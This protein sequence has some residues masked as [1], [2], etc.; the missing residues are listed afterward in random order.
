MLSFESAQKIVTKELE[1]IQIPDTPADLYDPVRYILKAGGKRIRPSLVLLGCDLFGRD[2]MKAIGPALGIELFHN[3][4]LLH[5]DLMDNSD[6]RRKNPTVHIRWN[7]NVAILSGDVMSIMANQ[8][9]CNVEKHILAHTLI[10][11]CY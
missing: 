11:S 7:P 6:L 3:F 2:Y 5:D 1:K 10:K 8:L 9:V 4:T